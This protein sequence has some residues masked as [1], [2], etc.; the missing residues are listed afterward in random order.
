MPEFKGETFRLKDI[1][2]CPKCGE[3]PLMRRDS[4]NRFQVWCTCGHKTKWTKK[5]QAVI[6]WY[7]DIL[8]SVF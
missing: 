8:R 6:E 5:T 3:A 7:N 4:S 1:A 2:V